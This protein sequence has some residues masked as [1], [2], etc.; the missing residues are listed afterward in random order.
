MLLSQRG[1]CWWSVA[2]P[3]LWIYHYNPWVRTH[4]VAVH[5]FLSS[6]NYLGLIVI[7]GGP[8]QCSLI[9]SSKAFLPNKVIFWNSI[10]PYPLRATVL[11]I[12]E[13]YHRNG[14]QRVKVFKD[15]WNKSSWR[16]HSRYLTTN[17]AQAQ[18]DQMKA[19][20][21]E[22]VLTEHQLRIPKQRKGAVKQEIIKDKVEQNL[23]R[24][25]KG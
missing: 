6:S 10:W 20:Q 3:G 5:V 16:Y 17:M 21:L 19:I 9:T 8:I 7:Q 25:K 14:K 23:F 11:F 2:F 12:I 4:W 18:T 1:A 15:T 22:L 24:F 13:T